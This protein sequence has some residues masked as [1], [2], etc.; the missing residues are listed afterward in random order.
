M[1]GNAFY[2]FVALS[3]SVGL[4][5]EAAPRSALGRYETRS[6]DKGHSESA[7]DGRL[8]RLIFNLI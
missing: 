7:W 5:P 2:S 6:G 8:A 3:G 1:L 4:D